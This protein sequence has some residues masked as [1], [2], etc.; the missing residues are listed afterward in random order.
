MK[1]CFDDFCTLDLDGSFS[2]SADEFERAVRKSCKI[3]E[4]EPLPQRLNTHGKRIALG[5]FWYVLVSGGRWAPER[6]LDTIQT[7]GAGCQVM[8]TEVCHFFK[9]SLLRGGM[10]V[11][12][13]GTQCEE[14]QQ[15]SHVRCKFRGHLLLG[16]VLFVAHDRWKSH[17]S[18]HALC[19]VESI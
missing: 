16:Y 2:L 19:I 13:C 1:S 17:S 14:Q 15:V 18:S 9:Q 4:D 11:V 6:T 5:A 7:R 10:F 3:T 12:W 8:D